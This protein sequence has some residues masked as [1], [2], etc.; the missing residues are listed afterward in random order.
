MYHVSSATLRAAVNSFDVSSE[1]GACIGKQ[2]HHLHSTTTYSLNCP[3]PKSNCTVL[4]MVQLPSSITHLV[5]LLMRKTVGVATGRG[6]GS[7]CCWHPG[8]G[9]VRGAAEVACKVSS[10]QIPVVSAIVAGLARQ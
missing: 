7:R 2:L 3:E 8:G 10:G 9:H 4:C 1:L 6:E 5:L